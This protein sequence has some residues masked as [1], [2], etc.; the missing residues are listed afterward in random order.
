MII[1]LVCRHCGTTQDLQVNGQ[2]Y[3]DWING[4][5]IQK[6]MPYLSAE[7][8]EWLISHTC[9]KCWD[10]IFKEEPEPDD[11]AIRN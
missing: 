10:E 4:T 3:L 7:D 9:P 8:R 5:L 1:C 6:A 11:E 2:D